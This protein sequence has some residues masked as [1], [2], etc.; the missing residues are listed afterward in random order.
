[1]SG[2]LFAG[3]YV[4]EKKDRFGTLVELMLFCTTNA[5]S[6]EE[7]IG[8]G[9]KRAR[10]RYSRESGWYNHRALAIQVPPEMIAEVYESQ[11]GP[12]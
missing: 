12:Q 1:M 7:A 11:D 6:E 5:I 10:T 8:Y 9:I 4:A 2:K 3:V